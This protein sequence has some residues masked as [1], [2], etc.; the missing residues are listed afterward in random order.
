MAIVKVTD[1]AVDRYFD[2]S[3]PK[4]KRTYNELTKNNTGYNT[5]VTRDGTAKEFTEQQVRDTIEDARQASKK[6]E[7]KAVVSASRAVVED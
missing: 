7:R 4:S 5:V 2:L 6:K 1:G 3:N